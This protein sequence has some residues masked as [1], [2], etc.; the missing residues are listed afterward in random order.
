[1]GVACLLGAAP[2]C[3][4][5]GAT[6]EKTE[7]EDGTVLLLFTAEETYW[8]LLTASGP[9]DSS[10]LFPLVTYLY[11]IC[12]SDRDWSSL[13]SLVL[14]LNVWLRFPGNPCSRRSCET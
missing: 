10:L 4:I 14:A 8:S 11:I 5:H 7:F 1:M 3:A 6:V 2:L 9:K 13:L 12:A